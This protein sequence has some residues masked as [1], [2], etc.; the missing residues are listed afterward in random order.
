V[1]DKKSDNNNRGEFMEIFDKKITKERISI[2]MDGDI[3]QAIRDLIKI[4]KSEASLSGAINTLLRKSITDA[5]DRGFQSAF[6]HRLEN[7]P[8]DTVAYL[9]TGNKTTA[10]WKAKIDKIISDIT[11]DVHKD[12]DILSLLILGFLPSRKD[13]ENKK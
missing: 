1:S 7:L 4:T 5:H 9:K 2:R 12:H 3:V 6:T 11:A 8:E 13:L 10:E